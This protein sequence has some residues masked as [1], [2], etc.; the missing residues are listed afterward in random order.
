MK[1][2]ILRLKRELEIKTENVIFGKIN[3][4]NPFISEQGDQL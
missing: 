1:N 3:D 2:A 4:G